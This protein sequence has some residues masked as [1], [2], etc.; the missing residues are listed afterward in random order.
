MRFFTISAMSLLLA[1]PVLGRDC[2]HSAPHRLNAAVG[3]ATSIVI[4]GRAGSLRV[5]GSNAA[6]VTA[7]GTACASERDVLAGMRIEG[8][9]EGSELVIEA[10]IPDRVVSFSFHNHA[11]LDF[12]VSVP[13]SLPIRI[14]DGSG[15]LYIRNVASADINDGSGEIEIRNVRGDVRLRDGSGS[16]EIEKVGGSVVVLADGSGALDIRDVRRDVTIEVDGS[17]G[18]DV[19]DV[20]G[21]FTVARDGSGG[22]DYDRVAGRVSIPARD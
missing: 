13:E 9:R 20:Q 22:V 18:I 6:N 10:V 8:R 4:V 17:G 16:V 14:K 1:A 21:N 5:T 7:T 15:G 3:D 11:T 19:A 2:D 12:E